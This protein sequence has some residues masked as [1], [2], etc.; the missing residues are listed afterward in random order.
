MVRPGVQPSTLGEGEASAAQEPQQEDIL[1]VA[2]RT[3]PE[4]FTL[5]SD[6]VVV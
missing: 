6:P 1:E 4:L 3:S 2:E 5:V